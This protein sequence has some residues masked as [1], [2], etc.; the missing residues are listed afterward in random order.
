M[1]NYKIKLLITAIRDLDEIIDNL[2]Q[3]SLNA[4]LKQYDRII[5]KINTL[6]QFPDMCEEYKTT[7]IGYRYRKMVI[8]NYFVFYIVIEDTIEIHRIINTRMDS[9]KIIE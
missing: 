4:A 1:K 8:D 7:V 3:F 2:S 9:S 5:D 6:K